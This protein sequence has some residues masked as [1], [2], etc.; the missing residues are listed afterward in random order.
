MSDLGAV[1]IVGFELVR[2]NVPVNARVAVIGVALMKVFLRQSR[3]TDEPW[4]KGESDQH[5]AE[6]G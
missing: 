3:G 1:M 5:A 4:H 2:L 6:P